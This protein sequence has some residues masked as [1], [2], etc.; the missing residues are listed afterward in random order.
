MKL[1]ITKV[2]IFILFLTTAFLTACGSDPSDTT[3]TVV[4]PPVISQTSFVAPEDSLG[5]TFTISNY[6]STSSVE[7]LGE[8]AGLFTVSIV[9][10]SGQTNVVTATILPITQFDYETMGSSVDLSIVIRSNPLEQITHVLS[11]EI[12]DV[13]GEPPKFLLHT[14]DVAENLS[15]A[16]DI[17]AQDDDNDNFLLSLEPEFDYQDFIISNNSLLFTTPANYETKVSY[18]V[19]I[20]ATETTDS[21]GEVISIP[22]T[23]FQYI[24]I[25]IIDV[26]DPAIITIAPSSL[27]DVD[28][29]ASFQASNTDE[30]NTNNI[31]FPLSNTTT[32]YGTYSISGT[33]LISYTIHP[34]VVESMKLE[35]PPY[36]LTDNITLTS[37][38]FTTYSHPI[39]ILA[40]NHP[41]ESIPDEFTI[42]FFLGKSYELD[43]LSNDTDVDSPNFRTSGTLTATSPNATIVITSQKIIYTPNQPAIYPF[44]DTITYSYL[45]DDVSITSNVSVT[46]V[47]PESELLDLVNLSNATETLMPPVVDSKDRGQWQVVSLPITVSGK[48]IVW[49]SASQTLS[50]LSPTTFIPAHPPANGTDL[51]TFL[52][53]TIVGSD[54]LEYSKFFP[55][56]IKKKIA[57]TNTK[58]LV[59]RVDFPNSQ[60]SATPGSDSQLVK[61]M[62]FEDGDSINDYFLENSSGYI[63]LQ[64]AILPPVPNGHP[65]ISDVDPS[66]G[67]VTYRHPVDATATIGSLG[68]EY[69][70][71]SILTDALT[72]LNDYVNFAQFDADNNGIL[73][74]VELNVIFI[75]ATC[76]RAFNGDDCMCTEGGFND[77]SVCKDAEFVETA[78]GV[79]PASTNHPSYSL[80]LDGKQIGG[81]S[82]SRMTWTSDHRLVNGN[83]ILEPALGTLAHEIG[84]NIWGISDLYGTSQYGIISWGL[85]GSSWL[86]WADNKYRPQHMTAYN[87]IKLGFLDPIIS[88][89]YSRSFSGAGESLDLTSFAST[90]IHPVLLTN[91]TTKS[92]IFSN[93]YLLTEVRDLYQGYDM[94]L[95]SI[96]P[97][98]SNVLS[99]TG[100]L[101]TQA[102]PQKSGNNN[103]ASF[104]D[105]ELQV[106]STTGNIK[107]D[108]WDLVMY[109]PTDTIT[110]STVPNT[111]FH[112]PA[113]DFSQNSSINLDS[114]NKFGDKY[115]VLLNN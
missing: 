86:R 91:Q 28:G 93:Q 74:S 65:T 50:F 37:Q 45:N 16:I 72:A 100:L 4:Q 55:I 6:V 61:D 96:E 101:I 62:M 115:T 59:I 15:L 88:T 114:I 34:S 36:K 109:S 107:P 9:P 51:E 8:D 24:D 108:N 33:G 106:K 110:T 68:L 23:S 92:A 13:V 113:V 111:N 95:G 66:D 84:H 78:P 80:M 77:N 82:K 67:V 57:I 104:R 2:K 19:R 26:N 40:T 70:A 87:K 58:Q 38:D 103:A 20:K 99:N 98:A 29:N 54:G 12:Q 90:N 42:T 89:P 56:T 48:S 30:D 25:N 69:P 10:V 79:H 97:Y 83:N 112:S 105:M 17:L 3:T 81:L 52:I 41:H 71:A 27:T 31:F 43:V 44:E 49:S 21:S 5:L 7:L 18:K 64:P 63:D 14:V 75:F 39:D 47:S 60:F 102:N 35:L 73:E 53:A 94:G 85:M 32:I 46:I 11:I 76:N 1:T 22:R